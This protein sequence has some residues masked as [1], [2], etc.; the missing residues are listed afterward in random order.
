[1][2]VRGDGGTLPL[3]DSSVSSR[4]IVGKG[5]GR[6]VGVLGGRVGDAGTRRNAGGGPWYWLT[7]VRACQNDTMRR[8]FR[9]H[10]FVTGAEGV[11][12]VEGLTPPQPSSM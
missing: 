1:M 9:I 3:I 2:G 6:P 12:G 7:D 5:Y 10:L 4:R 11:M 8:M